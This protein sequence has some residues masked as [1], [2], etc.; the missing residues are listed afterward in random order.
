MSDI[1]NSGHS[2]RIVTELESKSSSYSNIHTH[3]HTHTHTHSHTHKGTYR[4][5]YTHTHTHWYTQTPPPHPPTHTPNEMFKLVQKVG[6]VKIFSSS[7]LDC[8]VNIHTKQV[9]SASGCSN[10]HSLFT[11]KSRK[12]LPHGI[13]NTFVPHTGIIYNFS[14]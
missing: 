2:L 12:M 11:M 10:V 14:D 9:F 8:P 5:T 7:S 1:C 3:T 4:H 6:N 13:F